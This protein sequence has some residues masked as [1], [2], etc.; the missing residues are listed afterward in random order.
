MSEYKQWEISLP[1]GMSHIVQFTVMGHT[2][3]AAWQWF[4]PQIVRVKQRSTVCCV[5]IVHLAH[6][7]TTLSLSLSL[8]TY[9]PICPVSSQETHQAV[10]CSNGRIWEH[11]FSVNKSSQ[12]YWCIRIPDGLSIPAGMS[13]LLMRKLTSDWLDLGQFFG[14]HTKDRLKRTRLG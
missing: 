8:P 11:S 14:L 12:D 7:Y 9:L 6:G 4:C 5:A 3:V 1:H 2:V 13:V 10:H